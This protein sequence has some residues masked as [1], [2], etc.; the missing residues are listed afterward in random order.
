MQLQL[1]VILQHVQNAL[2]VISA[3]TRVQVLHFLAVLDSFLDQD[4]I[5]VTAAMPATSVTQQQRLRH[6][7]KQTPA[8]VNH[9]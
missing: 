9:A 4:L 1:T 5:N 7:W 6:I 2:L 3:H 8:L